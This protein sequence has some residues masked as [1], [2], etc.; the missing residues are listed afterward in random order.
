MIYLNGTN[1]YLFTLNIE[2]NIYYIYAKEQ[3]YSNGLD[4]YGY[5]LI[6]KEEYDKRCVKDDRKAYITEINANK[7]Q[8]EKTILENELLKVINKVEEKKKYVMFY[9][10]KCSIHK[11]N[12]SGNKIVYLAPVDYNSI[13]DKKVKNYFAYYSWSKEPYLA[14]AKEMICPICDVVIYVSADRLNLDSFTFKCPK[15]DARINVKKPSSGWV[16]I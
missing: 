5:Y 3:A 10:T 14:K 15:C 2:D 12:D 6:T 4:S 11:R 13:K 7:L 1:D 9:G 16:S 8:Y